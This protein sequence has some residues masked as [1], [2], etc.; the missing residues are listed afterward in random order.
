MIETCIHE[1]PLNKE[2]RECPPVPCLDA[3]A[4]ALLAHVEEITKGSYRERN[5]TE[6]IW[7]DEIWERAD[8]DEFKLVKALREALQYEW[9][10]A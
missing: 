7:N 3:A 4:R 6:W 10:R 2:C 1:V 8:P 9:I 5:G